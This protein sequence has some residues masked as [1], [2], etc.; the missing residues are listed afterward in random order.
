MTA[1]RTF[2]HVTTVSTQYYGERS[3][4]ENNLTLKS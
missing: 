2:V 3:F 1:G 4:Q